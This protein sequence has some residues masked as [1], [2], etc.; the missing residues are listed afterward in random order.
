MTFDF[1]NFDYAE[2]SNLQSENS[3]N[4]DTILK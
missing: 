4:F 2:Q 1:S 3:T